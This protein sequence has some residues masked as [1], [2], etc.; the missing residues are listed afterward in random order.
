MAHPHIRLLVFTGLIAIILI[1]CT[2]EPPPDELTAYETSPMDGWPTS[3]PEEQGIDSEKLAEMLAYIDEQNYEI[4]SVVV[5][6]HGNMVLEADLYPF[7]D[8]Q[9]HVIYSCT[10]RVMSALIGI[11]I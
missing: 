2:Q 11:A 3:T 6:R 1:G 10:K 7:K 9:R 4:G 8:G 5:I